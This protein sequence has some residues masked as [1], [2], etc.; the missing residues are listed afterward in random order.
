MR[1]SQ[2]SSDDD[3]VVFD[4]ALDCHTAVLIML[5]A[6]RHN[7]VCDLVTD[8]I[9]MAVADLLTSDDFHFLFLSAE[10]APRP[11][12]NFSDLPDC[13]KRD[14]CNWEVRTMCPDDGHKD[15]CE[16]HGAQHDQ[17]HR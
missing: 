5:Q 14:V 13:E 16:E 9:R 1:A 8:F 7:G 11:S 6:I 10:V 4:E 12:N 17:R 15:A 3:V 2:F